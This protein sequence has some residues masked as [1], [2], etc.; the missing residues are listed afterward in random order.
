MKHKNHRKKHKR[1]GSSG[2]MMLVPS[3]SSSGRHRHHRRRRDLNTI[4][5]TTTMTI[6]PLAGLILLLL[7]PVVLLLIMQN[8]H[9]TLDDDTL[10]QLA[11]IHN[12]NDSSSSS[13]SSLSL[14][15]WPSSVR[16]DAILPLLPSPKVQE[17]QEQE[18]QEQQQV[19]TTMKNAT[20]CTQL[21]FQLDH[22]NNNNMTCPI[23]SKS[24]SG[25]STC[26][27]NYFII[28][29]RKGGTTSL[30]TYMTAH[31]DIYP[32]KIH[33]TPQDGEAMYAIGSK[34]YQQI[35]QNITTQQQQQEQQKNW[36]VGDATVYR[37]LNDGTTKLPKYCHHAKLFILLRDPAE[38]CYSQYLMRYRLGYL[39]WRLR[40]QNNNNKTNNNNNKNMINLNPIIAKQ[41]DEFEQSLHWYQQQEQQQ[42]T[43][44]HNNNNKNNSEKNNT[45]TTTRTSTTTTTQGWRIPQNWY[46]RKKPI[47]T[48][49]QNCIYE[50]AYII[51]L[52][53]LINAKFPLSQ[54][55]IYW[56]IDF[57]Q[58]PN[59]IVQ[60]AIRF[61]GLNP[62]LVSNWTNIT[63]HVYNSKQQQSQQ[64]SEQSLQEH[65]LM[66]NT[67]KKP[68]KLQQQQ[69]LPPPP[70]L[71]P[72]LRARIYHLLQ[73]FDQEL[74]HF[75]GTMP[76]WISPQ[77]Q[78]QQQQYHHHQ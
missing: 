40:Q 38:R 54:I 66:S 3:S 23:S 19:Q 64:S 73:P 22:N 74:G 20:H 28:G 11:A 55:R 31:P 46:T 41:V 21:L 16:R 59:I 9:V 47:F 57:F 4:I 44:H 39:Q 5:T 1:D 29:T 72:I 25:P 52:R 50:G 63:S 17:Q 30:H 32:F 68:T 56:S 51:H 8:T 53:R 14:L 7:I 10:L 49:S 60:D 34:E 12:S 24:P 58:Q 6:P 37:F 77:Q 27:P 26:R 15:L 71:D 78:Q 18:Q 70:P 35:Y 69:Q 67:H 2:G 48:S 65:S 13:S 33:G 61:L 42:Q 45:T 75:L 43:N 62:F 76:P 36:I